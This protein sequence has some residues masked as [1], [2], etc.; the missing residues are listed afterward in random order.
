MAYLTVKNGYQQIEESDLVNNSNE[1]L[2]EFL[3]SWKNRKTVTSGSIFQECKI[4]ICDDQPKERKDLVGTP[5]N[6]VPQGNQSV[7]YVHDCS[8]TSAVN[9][10]E[11]HQSSLSD[12]NLPKDELSICFDYIETLAKRQQVK[13]K[14]IEVSVLRQLREKIE[15][16]TNSNMD[17]IPEYV[18]DIVSTPENQILQSPLLYK[19]QCE[20]N[21]NVMTTEIKKLTTQNTELNIELA[22]LKQKLNDFKKSARSNESKEGRMEYLE[23]LLENLE[24][25]NEDF[26]TKLKT[27]EEKNIV[28]KHDNKKLT[29]KVNDLRKENDYLRN[30][31]L[32]IKTQFDGETEKLYTKIQNLNEEISSL[33]NANQEL[34]C[35][36]FEVQSSKETDLSIIKLLEDKIE[37]SKELLEK[38]TNENKENKDYRAKFENKIKEYKEKLKKVTSH[39]EKLDEANRTLRE[40]N[41]ELHSKLNGKESEV[42][43][44][45]R[46]EKHRSDNSI[47]EKSTLNKTIDDLLKENEELKIHMERLQTTIHRFSKEKALSNSQGSSFS[48]DVLLQKLHNYREDNNSVH[49]DRNN[50]D[51][52]YK[53]DVYTGDRYIRNISSSDFNRRARTTSSFNNYHR[54]IHQDVPKKNNSERYGIDGHDENIPNDSFDHNHQTVQDDVYNNH[55]VSNRHGRLYSTD[56]FTQNIFSESINC[57][58]IKHDVYTNHVV[59]DVEGVYDNQEIYFGVKKGRDV[60]DID[61]QDIFD[62][63]SVRNSSDREIPKNIPENN[64]VNNRVM[65]GDAIHSKQVHDNKND[66]SNQISRN[67]NNKFAAISQNS[68]GIKISRDWQPGLF[69]DQNNSGKVISRGFKFDTNQSR[70]QV[71]INQDKYDIISGSEHPFKRD[72]LPS[73]FKEDENFSHKK[74][75]PSNN[76]ELHRKLLSDE[77]KIGSEA[78][79]YE[80]DE[81]IKKYVNEKLNLE[82]LSKDKNLKDDVYDIIDLKSMTVSKTSLNE[83]LFPAGNQYSTS[84]TNQKEESVIQASENASNFVLPTTQVGKV[85]YFEDHS[86]RAETTV[87]DIHSEDTK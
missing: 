32:S 30:T 40:I 59:S 17:S 82:D 27:V 80:S 5:G 43:D 26:R 86:N 51:D 28:L 4:S 38:I 23:A 29:I 79:K 69:P 9:R 16:I 6:S 15:A 46:K 12:E 37:N 81:I 83:T 20:Q 76:F 21:I 53:G 10:V 2:I 61:T 87:D 63:N 67:R 48:N 11:S 75:N 71:L 18:A 56:N 84:R 49:N 77:P 62:N 25:D 54:A 35:E 36:V 68:N 45:K 47:H 3:E 39:S 78:F 58:K 7:S 22:S 73:D 24:T 70:R 13:E 64:H 1:N 34:K 44:L 8:Q 57:D 55:Y 72:T 33:R 14:E 65:N 66:F 50:Y 52:R 31:E 60:Y 41:S 19:F 42:E 85:L 74:L